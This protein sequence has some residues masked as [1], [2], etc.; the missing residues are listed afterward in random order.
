MEFQPIAVD[1]KGVGGKPCRGTVGP[2]LLAA[3]GDLW[4]ES[5]HQL[6]RQGMT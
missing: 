2:A 5:P 3:V 4:P 1:S 6:T